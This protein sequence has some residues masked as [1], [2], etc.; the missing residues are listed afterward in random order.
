[1]ANFSSFATK[2]ELSWLADIVATKADDQASI[3]LAHIIEHLSPDV[4]LKC[5][6]ILEDDQVPTR[7]KL[8]S[9]VEWIKRRRTSDK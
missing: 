1:M 8:L 4:I 5:N 2:R 6:N 3:A 9:M 7:E